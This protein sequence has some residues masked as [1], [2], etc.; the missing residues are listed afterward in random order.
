MP[1][2]TYCIVGGVLMEKIIELYEK[3]KN[4]V[5]GGII[6]LILLGLEALMFWYFSNDINILRQDLK[7]NSVVKEV[8]KDVSPKKFT[9]DIKGEVKNP[10]VYILEEGKR[11]IDV[12]R[13]AGGFTVDA[14]STPNNLSMKIKDEMVIVIYSEDEVREFT[15]IKEEEAIKTEACQ[16][17][18]VQND[19]CITDETVKNTKKEDVSGDTDDS[20]EIKKVSLNTGTLE[21]LMTLPGIGEAKANSIIEYRK[22]KKFEKIEDIMEVSGIGEAVFEKLKDYITT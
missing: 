18:I 10:G 7:K 6:A 1:P 5:L 20:E 9:V 3:Y 2:P 22:E 15:K 4:Y 17:G 16:N 8:S 12:V 21:E 13:K 19:S 11:V 14:D